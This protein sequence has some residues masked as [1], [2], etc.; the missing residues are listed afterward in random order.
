MRN[1][2][3]FEQALKT[4][5]SKRYVE[6]Q[7]KLIAVDL[8]K[9][10]MQYDVGFAKADSIRKNIEKSLLNLWADERTT[11]TA[12][13]IQNTGVENNADGAFAQM[14]GKVN[15]DVKKAVD[16]G[17]KNNYSLNQ[18]TTIVNRSLNSGKHVART[19]ARTAQMAKIRSDYLLF[20][21]KN[22]CTKFRY[23]GPGSGTRDFCG[24]HKGKIYTIQEILKLNNGQGLPVL[25]YMGGWNCRHWW[26]AIYD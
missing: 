15:R 3:K 25:I 9:L 19:I 26:T 12:D 21:I 14:Q 17:L 10:S 4:A 24:L 6:G 23:D 20:H 5:I 2:K 13:K 11:K 7:P 22:G 18:I 8:K 16:R 1:Y